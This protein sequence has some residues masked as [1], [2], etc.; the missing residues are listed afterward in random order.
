[1]RFSG[2]TVTA[3]LGRFEI[4]NYKALAFQ[5]SLRTKATSCFETD[6]AT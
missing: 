6:V 5:P 1:M 2:V 3:S 4:F